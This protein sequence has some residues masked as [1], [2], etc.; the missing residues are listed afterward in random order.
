MELNVILFY[1]YK[2]SLTYNYYNNTD[3]YHKI[4]RK[5]ENNMCEN[6]TFIVLNIINNTVYSNIMEYCKNKLI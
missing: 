1:I 3:L 6:K 5:Y 4:N 2:R